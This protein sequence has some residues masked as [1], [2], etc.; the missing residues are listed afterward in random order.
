MISFKDVKSRV[1]SMEDIGNSTKERKKHV[2]MLK[3]VKFIRLTNTL[4]KL[5]VSLVL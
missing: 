1:R 2:N 5:L 3:A 4:Q